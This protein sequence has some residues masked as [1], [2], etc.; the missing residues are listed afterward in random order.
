MT[1]LEKETIDLIQKIY[2]KY[3]TGGALHVVIDDGNIEDRYIEW[4][5]QNSI[6]EIKRKKDRELFEI[7]ANNLLELDED[8]RN[9][10]CIKA[11]N[12]NY[13]GLI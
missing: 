7:C 12:P 2:K 6:P 5:L 8:I 4:C 3:P 11:F 13:L 9:K 10:C 1:K